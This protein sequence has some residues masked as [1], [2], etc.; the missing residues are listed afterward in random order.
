[1]KVKIVSASFVLLALVACSTGQQ[2]EVTP[3][4]TIVA[5]PVPTATRLPQPTATPDPF[6]IV[7]FRDGGGR[8]PFAFDPSEF[9]FPVGESVDFQF[10]PGAAF[11]T[12]T[13]EE[14]GID[15]EVSGSET[16][17]F[18]FTFDE[19]GTYKL[20]CIPH[21]ALGMIGTITVE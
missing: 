4:S 3:A 2:D 11:H 7:R 21:Q 9:S 13:V 8:G 15:V 16:I 12:F 6:E 5:Q 17:R 18:D 20:I 14:L 19:P 10:M 1:M